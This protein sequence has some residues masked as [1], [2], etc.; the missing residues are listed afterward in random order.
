MPHLATQG[1]ISEAELDVYLGDLHW[2]RLMVSVM[3]YIGQGDKRMAISDRFSAQAFYRKGQQLLMESLHPDPR[4][5][6]LIKELGEM[7]DGSRETLSREFRAQ[8]K[9]PLI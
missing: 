4:R 7:I 8:E 6:R 2:A 5:L 1:K 9:L 3:S